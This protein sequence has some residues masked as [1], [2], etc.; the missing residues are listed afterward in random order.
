VP[1]RENSEREQGREG[2]IYTGVVRFGGAAPTATALPG[3]KA[4]VV[5]DTPTAGS[6]I[7][8]VT[9]T[10]GGSDSDAAGRSAERGGQQDD[11]DGQAPDSRRKVYVQGDR[12][13]QHD[14]RRCDLAAVERDHR[15]C[16]NALQGKTSTSVG[17]TSASR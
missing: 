4:A 15:Y 7:Y 8:K 10:T 1:D 2:G 3:L 17:Q 11:A 9:K 6:V 16:G 5:F 13:Q 14:G 12:H